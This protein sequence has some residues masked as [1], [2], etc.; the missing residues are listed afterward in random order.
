MFAYNLSHATSTTPHSGGSPI[1][2]EAAQKA[3][4]DLINNNLNNIHIPLFSISS[5]YQPPARLN[6]DG[7]RSTEISRFIL[8]DCGLMAEKLLGNWECIFV[9][10]HKPNVRFTSLFPADVLA[11]VIL[12][13]A[14]ALA[15]IMSNIR[16]EG[17]AHSMMLSLC[18][19]LCIWATWVRVATPLPQAGKH[20]SMFYI[21]CRSSSH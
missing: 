10:P 15:P 16:H 18:R 12:S 9:S 8:F 17:A 5:L 20:P 1:G 4:A 7:R 19:L 11:A 13:L 3:Y 14:F 6:Y 2:A 21:R